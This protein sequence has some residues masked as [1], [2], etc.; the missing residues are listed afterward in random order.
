[1]WNGLLTTYTPAGWYFSLQ[2]HLDPPD[3]RNLLHCL[4]GFLL[5]LLLYRASRGCKYQPK[6][7]V[8]AVDFEIL[9]K[10]ERDDVTVQVGIL[11]RTERGEYCIFGY[12]SHSKP[13]QDA[14]TGGFLADRLTSLWSCKEYFIASCGVQSRCAAA[15][16]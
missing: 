16:G 4:S 2:S 3:S 11:D 8:G 14:Y 12:L 7:H 6:S 5:K 15:A 10:I 1:T 9:Y 13:P